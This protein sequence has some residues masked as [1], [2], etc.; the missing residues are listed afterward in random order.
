MGVQGSGNL[1]GADPGTK[2]RLAAQRRPQASY[3]HKTGRMNLQGPLQSSIR[4]MT[5]PVST[6]MQRPTWASS[7]RSTDRAS[8]RKEGYRGKP[9][10][11]QSQGKVGRRLGT[12]GFRLRMQGTQCVHGSW[13]LLSSLPSSST[14]PSAVAAAWPALM[15]ASC[16]L[17]TV[18]A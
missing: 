10:G 17:G 15:G 2:L 18:Q 7:D 3:G 9:R 13:W 11:S 14:L 6:G 12:P 4:L 16:V 5:K 1:D 8:P